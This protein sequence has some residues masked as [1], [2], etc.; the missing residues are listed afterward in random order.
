M[1]KRTIK[2]ST[3]T[4][5]QMLSTPE[6][7]L[8]FTNEFTK[9]YAQCTRKCVSNLNSH[10]DLAEFDGANVGAVNVRALSKFLLG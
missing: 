10:A 3:V 6:D 7:S 9:L 1:L 4:D 8:R 5:S 2:D